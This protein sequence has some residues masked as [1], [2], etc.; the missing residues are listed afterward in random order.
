[1]LRSFISVFKTSFAN[2]CRHSLVFITNFLSLRLFSFNLFSSRGC[3]G[4]EVCGEEGS[5]GRGEKGSEVRHEEGS[6]GRAKEGSKACDEEGS[7]AW[8]EEVSKA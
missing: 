8:G 1:M 6:E 2:P 5:V 4:T 7:E 3:D